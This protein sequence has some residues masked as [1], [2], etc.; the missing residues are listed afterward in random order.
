MLKHPFDFVSRALVA[1]LVALSLTTGLPTASAIAAGVTSEAEAKGPE[2]A[3]FTLKNG[4]QV[5]VIPDR[6]APVVTHMV[7]YKAGSADEP[8]GKSGI[9][10]YLEHLMFKG[11]KAYPGNTF[12][13]RVA[14]I[15]GQE[16]AFTSQDYTAYFQRVPPEALK[17]MMTMEAD[18]MTNLV[19]T[20]ELIIPE[21][22]VIQEERRTR[23][24]NNPGS[25]LSEAVQSAMFQNHRYGIP[26]IGWMHEVIKLDKDDAIAFYEKFYT[27]NN[28]ILVVAGDVEVDAVLQ[29]AKD[30]YGKIERRADPERL[31]RPQEPPPTAARSV[32]LSDPRVRAPSFQRSYLVPSYGNHRNLEAEALDLLSEILGGSTT[33]RIYR[34]LVVEKK[35]ASQA[36]GYYQGGAIDDT[37][38]IVYATPRPGV[39]LS[40]ME[41]GVDELIAELLKEGVQQSEVDR[42]VKR[43]IR[44]TIFSRDSQT[45]MAR[46]YGASLVIGETVEEVNKWPE[47]LKAISVD[48]INAVARKY[49]KPNRSVSG[50]L[51]PASK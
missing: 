32:S 13:A 49:L 44:S 40:Q 20:D 2:V 29:L 41:E 14:E 34:K 36:G 46:V 15:G 43:L 17:D 51:T 10:H 22:D 27:P 11:T 35:L 42:S 21:R 28:A 39:T 4:M 1:P 5:V 48:Q 6:R 25:L 8:A 38:F 33:S 50:F 30:I 16:N 7:W 47:R 18:R 3:H 37:R 31:V 24:D 9:A 12:S 45:T 23:T 26:I 19:L